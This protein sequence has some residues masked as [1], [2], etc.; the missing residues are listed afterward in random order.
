MPAGSV[1]V[2]DDCSGTMMQLKSL[3]QKREIFYTKNQEQLH[4]IHRINVSRLNTFK[5]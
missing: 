4:Q 5:H 3:Q 1:T 2:M